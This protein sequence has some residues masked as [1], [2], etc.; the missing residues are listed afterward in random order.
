MRTPI[1][2]PS[3]LGAGPNIDMQHLLFGDGYLA[4]DGTDFPRVSKSMDH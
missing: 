2:S 3:H 4:S 1:Q